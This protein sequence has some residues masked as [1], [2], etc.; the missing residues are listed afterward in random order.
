M[1]L[2]VLETACAAQVLCEYFRA[3]EERERIERQKEEAELQKQKRINDEL[4]QARLQ[5]HRDKMIKLVETAIAEKREF[6]RVAASQ[7]EMAIAEQARRDAEKAKRLEHMKELRK[8]I[9]LRSLE[10]E[11]LKRRQSEEAEAL[12]EADES[13]RRCIERARVR[14]IPLT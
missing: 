10:L 11:K 1:T 13:N 7:R 2:Q 14:R 5:Q 3:M 12:R 6:E 8:Q 4:A 9:E